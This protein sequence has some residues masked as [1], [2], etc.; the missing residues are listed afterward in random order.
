[1]L[2]LAV[3]GSPISHSLSPRIHQAAYE[4]MGVAASYERFEVAEDSFEN[5][6]HTHQDWNG[7]SLTMPLKAIGIEVCGFVTDAVKEIAAVNTL[8]SR[9][10]IWNG[11][12]TDVLGFDY[13]LK[14][15]DLRDIAILGAGGTAKAALYALAG[16]EIGARVYRRSASRDSQLVRA[17]S[18]IEIF[19]W[20]EV[21]DAFSASLLINT[22]PIAA[23]DSALKALSPKGYVLDSLYH[24]WPTPLGQSTHPSRYCSGKDLLVAQALFQIEL[25]TGSIID[26]EEFFKHLRALI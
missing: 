6:F 12:N 18:R 22:L 21:G 20:E 9:D 13:L 24:P 4:M 7:F 16:R 17:N 14:E 5:F 10:G 1:M 3:L 19:S 15:R 26:K 23:F 8:V 11:Y 2:K 25:F